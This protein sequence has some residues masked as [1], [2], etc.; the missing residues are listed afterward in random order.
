MRPNPLSCTAAVALAIVSVAS[1][2]CA[3]T[4]NGTRITIPVPAGMA[5]RSNPTAPPHGIALGRFAA[6]ST[7][8]R[9][10]SQGARLAFPFYALASAPLR[11][12]TNRASALTLVDH[13]CNAGLGE[14]DP[15]Q[16]VAWA[17]ALSAGIA[18]KHGPLPAVPEGV[19]RIERVA[20]PSDMCVELM[21]M[22]EGKEWSLSGTA[23]IV[24]RSRAVALDV[25]SQNPTDQVELAR[26]RSSLLEWARAVKAANPD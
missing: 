19:L 21:L 2:G 7:F 4:V 17:A 15:H 13:Q 6:D 5:R 11:N 23:L 22:R 12:N 3:D 18:G 9:W 20:T 25:I 24:V 14:P 26:V 8:A 1:T 10:Q 16:K